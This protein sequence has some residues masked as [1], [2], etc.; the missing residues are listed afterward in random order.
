MIILAGSWLVVV[1]LLVST[2]AGLGTMQGFAEDL[3]VLEGDAVW[4][5]GIAG[6]KWCGREVL[7]VCGRRDEQAKEQ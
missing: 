4:S 6:K 1:A 3:S 2:I 5:M 7:S